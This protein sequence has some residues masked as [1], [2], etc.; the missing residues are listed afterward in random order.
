MATKKTS[1]VQPIVDSI[2]REIGFRPRMS[3]YRG[4]SCPGRSQPVRR[5]AKF[6]P[7][8][9]AE[10]LSTGIV[11]SANTLLHGFFDEDG[12]T[13]VDRLVDIHSDK[14]ANMMAEIQPPS[15][16]PSSQPGNQPG[17]QTE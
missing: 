12:V 9:L 15:A 17:N 10:G 11:S 6:A 14:F 2:E 7:D 8:L 5:R 3:A 4:I 1:K 16:D 13:K